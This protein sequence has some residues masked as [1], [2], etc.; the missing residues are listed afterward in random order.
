MNAVLCTGSIATW[1]N[2]LARSR[3][4]SAHSL[5][6]IIFLTESTHLKRKFC[7]K[8][9]R[10]NKTCR[11]FGPPFAFVSSQP[12]RIRD[13]WW[14]K[15]R[16]LYQF[17]LSHLFLPSQDLFRSSKMP[18]RCIAAR[19]SNVKDLDRSTSMDKIPFFGDVCRIKKKRRKKW[20]DFV[21]ERRKMWVLGED[22]LVV[23]RTLCSRWLS[24]AIKHRSEL[25]TRF[26]TRWNWGLCFPINTR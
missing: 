1:L 3:V 5:K 13:V 15:F 14:H 11:H 2:P 9:L 10:L 23:F 25:K 18:E 16:N 7:E 4:L 12:D 6:K 22:V 8:I 26:K 17:G 24:K 19:C 21:L 20:V